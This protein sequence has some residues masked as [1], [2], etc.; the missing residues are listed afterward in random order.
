MAKT[1]SFKTKPSGLTRS[2]NVVTRVQTPALPEVWPVGAHDSAQFG[3]K[4][5]IGEGGGDDVAQLLGE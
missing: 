3:R 5:R 2:R 1:E 4:A